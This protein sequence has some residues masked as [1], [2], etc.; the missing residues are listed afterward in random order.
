M[1]I[2]RQK[3]EEEN[4][5]RRLEELKSEVAIATAEKKKAKRKKFDKQPTL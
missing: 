4:E 1:K 2:I 3:K 5:L